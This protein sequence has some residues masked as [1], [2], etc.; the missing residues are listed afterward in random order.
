MIKKVKEV[1]QSVEESCV[2]HWMIEVAVS[3]KSLGTCKK[4]NQEKFFSNSIIRDDT[5]KLGWINLFAGDKE[6]VGSFD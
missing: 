2:H 6:S 3:A 5:W 4:C 1:E